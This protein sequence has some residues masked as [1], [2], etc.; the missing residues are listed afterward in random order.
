MWVYLS[1]LVKTGNTF[2][3]YAYIY[4][5]TFIIMHLTVVYVHLALKYR[6]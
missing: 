4:T 5:L 3:L 6:D 2:M 1:H